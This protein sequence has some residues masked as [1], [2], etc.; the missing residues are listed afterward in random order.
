MNRTIEPEFEPVDR[1]RGPLDDDEDGRW[2]EPRDS[3][4]INAERRRG[5]LF[6]ADSVVEE[7]G[8][9]GEG[10]EDENPEEEDEEENNGASA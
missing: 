2:L 8:E 9:G 3:R 5:E 4:R 7:G 1:H 10:G 6:D